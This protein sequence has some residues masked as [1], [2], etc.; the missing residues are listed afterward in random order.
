[1]AASHAVRPT[2]SAL[3]LYFFTIMLTTA[4]CTSIDCPLNS[5]VYTQYQLMNAAGKVDTLADTLT[6]FTTRVDGNDSVLINR[7]VNTTEIALPISYAQKQDIFFFQTKDTLYK[8][9]KLDTVTI[10]KE[11]IPHFESV[12]CSP[13]F[14]HKI[15]S[16][17]CT[18]NAID[19]IVI[20][21][22][23]VTMTH[24]RNI[25]SYISSIAISLMLLLATTVNAQEKK[26][27]KERQRAV[28][29]RFCRFGRPGW[30]GANVHRRLRAI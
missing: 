11:D 19:S 5:L 7:N 25:S 15:T 24:Q 16:V 4:A 6:I 27:G 12:D 21:N 13:S 20:N 17:S 30:P 28:V 9:T 18:H 29:Q 14:F 1:M 23:D 10:E 22:H 3:P 8:V 26:R 2:L